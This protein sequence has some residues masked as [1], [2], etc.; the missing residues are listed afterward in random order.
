MTRFLRV[1]EYPMPVFAEIYE[2]I[3][4][5]TSS[6][7]QVELA[8]V[9][10]IRQS[11]ISDA[12][13]RNSVPGD[14]YMKL[15]EKYGLNPDWLKQGVGP[16]YLRTEQG[17][18]PQDAPASLAENA[19]HYG[20]ALAKNSVCTE[21]DMHCAYSDKKPRPELTPAGKISLPLSLSREGLLVLRMRGANMSPLILPGAHLGVDTLDNNVVSGQIYALFA[22]NE[23]LMLR[24]V[25][26]N[27]EQ[28]GYLL[29]SESPDFPE[30]SLTP[31]LL[32]KRLLGKVVWILQ[33]L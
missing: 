3:K 22:P 26:L 24:R 8:E 4:L 11:S 21:Y 19:A 10:D 12:K 18:M 27:G 5:A 33:E 7:T 29:R 28:D 32:V 30:I 2:R 9:L 6:R 25:F 13:R 23:G 16:M 15:F 1:M 31:D 14:W 17:Y 20:D